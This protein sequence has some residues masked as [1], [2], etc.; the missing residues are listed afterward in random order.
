MKKITLFLIALVTSFS[1][2]AQDTSEILWKTGASDIDLTI[3]QGYIVIW[4]WSDLAEHNVISF[5]DSEE[6]FES[7]D[8]S[9]LG[10]AFSHKFTKTGDFSFRCTF[11]PQTMFG[12]IHVP[13]SG[14]KNEKRKKLSI[15]P[16]PVFNHL[17]ISSPI[18]IEK[19]SNTNVS[20]R[21][22]LERSIHTDKI[23]IDMSNYRNGMYFMQIE[24]NAK[25][26]TYRIIKK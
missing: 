1:F 24:S 22:V 14:I 6:V 25:K 15:Y 9:G 8:M 10:E 17:N 18:K 26:H 5:S 16:N 4:T 19:I 3:D 21:K 12:T 7:K 2:F 11:H 13:V 20:G 23:N